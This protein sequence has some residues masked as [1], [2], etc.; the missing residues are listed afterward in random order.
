MKRK[1]RHYY[2]FF[3]GLTLSLVILFFIMVPLSNW[4]ANNKIARNHAHLVSLE[5]GT[6]AGKIYSGFDWFYSLWE[7]PV[8]AATSNN[9]SLWAFTVLGVPLSDPVGLISNLVNSVHFPMKFLLGGLIPLIVAMLLGRVFCAWLCPMAVLF[10]LTQKV[11]NWM[12]KLKIPL[13]TVRLE[14]TTRVYVFWLGIL[15][16]YF[17]GAWVWH[18]ILPYIAFTHEI[19]AGIVF[20]SVTVGSYFLISILVLDIGLIPEEYCNS[21]CPTGWFLSFIGQHSLFQLKANK[22]KCPRKCSKCKDIC[23]INLFPKEGYL[24]SCHLCMKCVESCPMQ[25]IQ[26]G[27]NSK[28]LILNTKEKNLKAHRET[29]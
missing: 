25:H 26:L 23:P 10:G 3:R 18:F 29:V 17:F 2:Q 9:G 1:K 12:L 21:I 19:F 27:L 28:Y 24:Y 16:S 22:T 11:R 7:D 6:F 14:R 5:F 15:L 4:Y 8:T 20:S 13:L